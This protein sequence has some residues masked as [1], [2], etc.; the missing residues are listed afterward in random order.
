MYDDIPFD[1]EK[2]VMKLEDVGLT[3]LFL[4][5]CKSLGEI[6]RLLGKE[7]DAKE[8]ER[9]G[10]LTHQGLDRLWNEE[11]GCYCN[12]R[13]DT[14]E[15]STRLS[16]TN[17]Y[18]LYDPQVPPERAR[19]MA[20]EHYYNPQE[21]YGE[22]MMPA[23][24]RNDPA[25][26]DQDYWRGRVWPSTNFL[27]YGAIRSCGCLPDV[28]EDLAKHSVALMMKEWNEHRHIHENYNANTGEG[29][30]VRNSDKFYHWGALL[31]LIGMLESGEVPGFLEP[32]A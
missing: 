26:G 22:W 5:D 8:L 6:A 23:I 3:G 28:A 18:A 4:L 15:F 9:R 20:D 21:F 14:G 24:A 30:D 25:Y 11:L 2:H 29:C 19:R 27:A 17:F 16:P 32:L 13:T 7:A 10:A 1:K 12:L 31:G